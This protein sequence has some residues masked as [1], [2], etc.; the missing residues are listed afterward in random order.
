MTAPNCLTISK[1]DRERLA[2][3]I[4]LL[5]SLTSTGERLRRTDIIDADFPAHR[6]EF[7]RTLAKARRFCVGNE[8][9]LT[10]LMQPEQG[11][12]V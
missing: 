1:G 11:V 2:D 3:A 5:V 12:S 8:Q 9:L 6:D 4:A 10:W 7:D